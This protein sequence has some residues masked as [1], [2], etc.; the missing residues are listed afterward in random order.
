MWEERIDFLDFTLNVASDRRSLIP[1][2]GGKHHRDQSENGS[3]FPRCSF[4]R[5]FDFSCTQS[6]SSQRADSA[7]IA[8]ICAGFAPN[9]KAD[10][11][12][13]DSSPGFEHFGKQLK[14]SFGS[15]FLEYT[16]RFEITQFD[17][18]GKHRFDY[19]VEVLVIL[20]T[21]FLLAECSSISNKMSCA[22]NRIGYGAPRSPNTTS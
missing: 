17:L 16:M 18:L 15:M 13:A 11:L 12:S 3:P 10:V 22:Y 20:S 9:S 7:A 19:V 14:G 21:I 2:N 6:S 8:R 1:W 5:L 4:Q